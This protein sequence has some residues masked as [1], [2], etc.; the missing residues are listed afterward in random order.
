MDTQTTLQTASDLLKPWALEFKTPEANRV[1]VYIESGNLIPAVKALLDQH[2]GYLSAITGLDVPATADREGAVEVLYHF[3]Q[4]S[5][6][7][8]L[9]LKVPYSNASV[10]S[11]CSLIPSVTLYER[12]LMEMYGVEV[13]GTPNTD[14]LL[15][16]DDWP[17][18]VYP[19]RKSFTGL[20]QL[21]E[22][23]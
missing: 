1:D 15:L 18:G 3:C 17:K 6:I 13:L 5:A 20:D 11:V 4:D 21:T 12:E 2:L 22:E 8:T 16:P 10:P 7:V 23:K 9:R 19:M 14:R